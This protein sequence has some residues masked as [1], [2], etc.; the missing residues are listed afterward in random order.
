MMTRLGSDGQL[1]QKAWTQISGTTSGS[2]NTAAAI[3][4]GTAVVSEKAIIRNADTN[5]VAISVG[6]SSSANH[7]LLA[8][9]DE[10]TID[11][12]NQLRFNIALWFV[13]SASASQAYSVIYV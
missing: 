13:K 1:P 2:A 12:S 11:C 9:G 7:A 10:Y 6:P 3:N 5:T 8:P 4:A